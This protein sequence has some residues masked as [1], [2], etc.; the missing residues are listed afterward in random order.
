[1]YTTFETSAAGKKTEEGKGYKLI[2]SIDGTVF[3]TYRDDYQP[4]CHLLTVLDYLVG[5]GSKVSLYPYT[6]VDVKQAQPNAWRLIPE[7]MKEMN[8][9]AQQM[10][11]F[12]TS[13]NNQSK[14]YQKLLMRHYDF[15]TFQLGDHGIPAVLICK[16]RKQLKQKYG[17]LTEKIETNQKFRTKFLLKHKIKQFPTKKNNELIFQ[18]NDQEMYDSDYEFSENLRKNSPPGVKLQPSTYYSITSA[19]DIIKQIINMDSNDNDDNSGNE[20]NE[21]KMKHM[22]RYYLPQRH[23]T[24]FGRKFRSFFILNIYLTGIT[25]RI[26]RTVRVPARFTL[27][28]FHDKVLCP[29]FGWIRNFHNYTFLVPHREDKYVGYGATQ[30]YS[31]DSCQV[32][33]GFNLGDEVTAVGSKRLGSNT[34]MLVDVLRKV[35]DQLRYIYDLGDRFHHTITLEKIVTGMDS[36]SWNIFSEQGNNTKLDILWNCDL[37]PIVKILDGF[38]R[39]PPENTRGNKGYIRRLNVLH[40]GKDCE[41]YSEKIGDNV[42][43]ENDTMDVFEALLNITTAPNVDG[44]W[45]DCL[46]FDIDK[47]QKQL[48]YVFQTN[49]SKYNLSKMLHYLKA[50]YPSDIGFSTKKYRKW[51]LQKCGHLNICHGRRY[52][53]HCGKQRLKK[54]KACK[55]CRSAFYCSRKC[56]KSEWIFH[57]L[58]CFD[59]TKF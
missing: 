3:A 43:R 19:D 24:E 48:E 2:P 56:Q 26:Y 42:F 7:M 4:I 51:F 54:I 16:K 41:K 44:S 8:K 25:P 1:M 22:Q 52:C 50:E 33:E 46:E 35:G 57:K 40:T 28:I 30:M 27:D 58:V 10:R 18:F 12:T 36:K 32:V 53:Y 14:H 31:N 9:M 21:W 5:Y 11:G 20:S 37:K 6:Q 55:A 23:E 17:H 15:A 59:H 45:F 49:L 13:N 47:K 29:I 39:G 34:I 38:G